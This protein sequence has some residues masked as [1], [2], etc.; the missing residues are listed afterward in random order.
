MCAARPVPVRVHGAG[1][2]FR[3]SRACRLRHARQSVVT[4]TGHAPFPRAL[5]GQ[6]LP[7]LKTCALGRQI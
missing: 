3:P 2:Q 5:V 1:C 4:A 7:T 6:N